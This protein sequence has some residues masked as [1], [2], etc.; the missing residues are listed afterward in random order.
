M[1]FCGVT[2]K[3]IIRKQ[4][5]DVF[6]AEEISLVNAVLLTVCDGMGGAKAGNIASRMA[7]DLF[8]ERM[9]ERLDPFMTVKSATKTLRKAIAEVNTALYEKNLDDPACRGMG[10]TLVAALVTESWTIV[11]NVGDSR[12]YKVTTD[13]ISQITKDHSV[14]EDLIDRGDIS[15]FEALHHPNRHLITRALGTAQDIVPDVFQTD[16]NEGDSIL[17]CS[18]GLTNLVGDQELLYEVLKTQDVKESCEQ[19]IK[20]ALIRGAPDNVTAVLLR[21]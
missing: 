16:L 12:A 9:I 19:L 2:D 6:L 8:R 11:L 15:R 3:G 5:Q 18:D 17:L 1:D 4:N 10:T 20:L 7:L 21:K 14:V 13:G